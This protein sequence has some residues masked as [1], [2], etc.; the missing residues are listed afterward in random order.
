MNAAWDYCLD[1]IASAPDIVLWHHWPDE[2][3]HQLAEPGDGFQKLCR[4]AVNSLLQTRFG[5]W[6]NAWLRDAA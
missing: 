3:I 4:E 2:R 1:W 6:S 5:R